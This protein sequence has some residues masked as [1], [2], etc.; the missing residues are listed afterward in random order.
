MIVLALGLEEDGVLR[1]PPE[2]RNRVAAVAATRQYLEAAGALTIR[3]RFA[4][5][6]LPRLCGPRERIE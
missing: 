3:A 5:L 1:V 4:L 2:V 6:L